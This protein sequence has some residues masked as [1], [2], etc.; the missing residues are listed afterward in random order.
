MEVAA[1]LK[2][3]RISPQKARL[4]ARQIA[5]MPVEKALSL[6]KFSPKK[7][8]DL[9][10]KVLHS[11]IAN[12][13]HNEGADVDRLKVNM[14]CVDDAP[15]FKRMHARARG[16]GNRITKRNSHITIKVGER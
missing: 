12:A 11:A 3:A 1:Q 13:E 16:R 14:I 7:A 2:H 15:T 10:C 8:G 5:G 4:V 6:L 9:I